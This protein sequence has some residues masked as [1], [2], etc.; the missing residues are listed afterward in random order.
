MDESLRNRLLTIWKPPDF[1]TFF[2]KYSKRPPLNIKKGG[3]IF[4]EGDQP[5]KIYFIAE[6]FVKMHHASEDGKETI[7]YLY[8]PG[9]ILGVRALTSIDRD[10]KHDAKAITDVKI[11]TMSREDYIDILAK[12]PEYLVDLLHV[13]IERLNYTEKKLEGFIISDATSRV[14]AFL[15]NCLIRFGGKQKGEIILPV[16][17]T[18]QDIADFVGSFRETVTGAIQHLEKEKVLIYKREGITILDIQKLKRFAQN[19]RRTP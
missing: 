11:I 7:I 4:Y 3:N 13:F 1:T 16:P 14:A 8:G 19:G 9:S 12:N 17:L 10:L 2:K 18:H 6:G 15:Y 5:E